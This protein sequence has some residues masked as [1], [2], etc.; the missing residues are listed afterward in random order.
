M[1]TVGCSKLNEP[2]YHMSYSKFQSLDFLSNTYPKEI[3][4]YGF[5]NL[6]TQKHYLLSM[7][8]L[9][10]TLTFTIIKCNNFVV[11]LCL[12]SLKVLKTF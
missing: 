5:A 10:T 3:Q 1:H 2:F 4:I 12:L 9:S 11:V 7:L 6:K 8:L